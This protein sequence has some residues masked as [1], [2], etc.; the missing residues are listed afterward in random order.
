MSEIGMMLE[1]RRLPALPETRAEMLET[2]A[3]LEYGPIPPAPK[4]LSG[5]KTYEK[6]ECAGRAVYEEHLLTAQMDSF[7]ASFPVRCIFS[8]E[9]PE[10]GL[11]LFVFINFRRG[12]PDWYFPANEIADAG[13]AVVSLCYLDV[14]ADADDGYSTGVA[15]DMIRAYGPT[16][17]IS[18]WAWACSRALDWALSRGDIDPAR[19]AVIGHSRL[20]K[21]A[22]WAGANDDRFALVISNDSGC[23]GA[24]LSRDK[25]GETIADITQRFPYWSVDAYKSFAGREHDAPFDQHWLLAACAPRRVYV[26]SASDDLWAGP[27]SEYLSCCAASPAWEKAGRTG[28]IH[29]DRLPEVGE[30]LRGGSVAYH[31]RRGGH[32]LDRWDWQRYMEFLAE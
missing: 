19:T 18:L 3:R 14:T 16:S 11:P 7:A 32:Y 24:A 5:E 29:P 15:P 23:S 30:I 17:K 13:F 20:G 8:A 1:R 6:N 10:K 9:K 28:F 25:T 2:L 4:R 12:V 27:D 22:L 21:T 31:L 26:A